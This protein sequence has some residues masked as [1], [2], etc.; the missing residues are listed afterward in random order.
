MTRNHAL[1][2]AVGPLLPIFTPFRDEPAGGGRKWVY[3]GQPQT[4]LGK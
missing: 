3:L 1:L 2:A 4:T